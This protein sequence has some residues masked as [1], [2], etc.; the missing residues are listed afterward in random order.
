MALDEFADVSGDVGEQKAQWDVRQA[1][2]EKDRATAL[3]PDDLGMEHR[4]DVVA[5]DV[6]SREEAC[7]ETAYE[8]KQDDCERDQSPMD[9]A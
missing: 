7:Q 2:G 1:D 9:W 4:K 6:F 3:I 8:E 5:F